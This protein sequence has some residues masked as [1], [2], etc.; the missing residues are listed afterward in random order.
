MVYTKKMHSGVKII[1][2]FC[3]HFTNWYIVES[4]D[5]NQTQ[6]VWKYKQG[7]KLHN[8]IW[9]IWPMILHGNCVKKYIYD[10]WSPTQK[11]K[12]F[13]S[14][15]SKICFLFPPQNKRCTPLCYCDTLLNYAD[16]QPSWK[17]SCVKW[18]VCKICSIK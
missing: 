12:T 1:S 4:V 16:I 17:K 13:E 11:K 15:I 14:H 5:I 7:L 18:N 3:M 9:I 6:S 10:T 8:T 2:I